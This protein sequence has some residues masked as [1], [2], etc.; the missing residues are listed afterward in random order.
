VFQRIVSDNSSYYVLAYYPPSTKRDG[1]FHRIDVRTTNPVLKV[2]A[3]RGYAAPRG[4]PSPIQVNR[5]DTK[6][7][8]NARTNDA[9]APVLDALN[10][11]IPA[12]GIG[13]RIFASPFKG[14]A[15]N[16]SVVLGIELRGRDLPIQQNGR[17]EVSFAAVDAFGKTRDGDTQQLSLALPQNARAQVEQHG[18]Q[19]LNRLAMPP[20]RYQVRVGARNAVSGAVGAV[21]YDLDIPDFGK[22]PLSMSG[23]LVTS[24]TRA[25]AATARGDEQLQKLM[26]AAPVSRRTFTRDDELFVFAE[27]YDGPGSTP[28]TVD[29]RTSIQPLDGGPQQFQNA[30]ERSSREFQSTNGTYPYSVRIPM[31]RLGAGRYV[32]TVEATSRLGPKTQ[33]Q[34]PFE[35]ADK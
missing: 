16:A 9:S 27:I 24:V 30:E 35:V 20:G 22:L 18:L 5:D 11:P 7:T 4:T 17:V 25:G 6:G 28:H 32:L 1:K 13:L 29:I 34:I 12:T 33:R 14:A 15:A 3:R 23:V 10:S 19:I 2:R 26:P 8:T 31:S 21:S